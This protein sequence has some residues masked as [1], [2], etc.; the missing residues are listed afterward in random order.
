MQTQNGTATIGLHGGRGWRRL[1]AHTHIMSGSP[2][3]IGLAM[4]VFAVALTTHFIGI[5]WFR[6]LRVE[7]MILPIYNRFVDPA[8]KV[9]VFASLTIATR[10]S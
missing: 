2:S 9:K 4:L 10:R 3:V 6:L 7:A 8:I 1:T 5:M